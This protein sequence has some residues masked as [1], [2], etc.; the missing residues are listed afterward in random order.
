MLHSGNEHHNDQ[1]NDLTLASIKQEVEA[2]L[3]AG[4][5][6]CL[7]PNASHNLPICSLSYLFLSI[8]QKNE[9]SH[10]V[11]SALLKHFEIKSVSS[12][13][14]S[15]RVILCEMSMIKTCTFSS[16]IHSVIL[17]KIC[18]DYCYVFEIIGAKVSF[19]V[20]VSQSSDTLCT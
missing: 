7:F 12:K 16:R 11:C 18:L 3:M 19:I 5:T 8:I 1:A 17:C 4:A 10:C 15:V 14:G 6:P 20:S 9:I 2:E 13:L